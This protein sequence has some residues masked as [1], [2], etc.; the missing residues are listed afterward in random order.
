MPSHA[1]RTLKVD[2]A[3]QFIIVRGMQIFTKAEKA[4]GELWKQ[5]L[6]HASQDFRKGDSLG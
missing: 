2:K 1:F 3:L 4:W 5:R 6:N